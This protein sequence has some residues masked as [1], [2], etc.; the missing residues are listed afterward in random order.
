M[1]LRQRAGSMLRA[2]AGLA[3]ILRNIPT[4]DLWY[5][6]RVTTAMRGGHP[7]HCPICGF[8][9][10]FRAFGSPPRYDAECPKCR[11]LER[12]R[13]LFLAMETTYPIQPGSA[14]LHFAPEPAVQAFVRSRVSKYVTTDIIGS[15]VD[16]NLN[17]EKIALPDASYDVIVCS[18]VLEHV[19]D[20]FALAEMYRVLRP[21]GSLYVMA[22]VIEGWERTYENDAID[23]PHLREIYFGQIDHVR[24]Y[25]S[26]IRKRIADAGFEFSE[27]TAEGAIVV[28]H[29]LWRGEKIFVCLKPSHVE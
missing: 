27:F 2:S 22:P 12:H 23:T 16:L 8:R 29:G 24:F 4:L 25:G 13:L 28:D 7:R 9:G 21:G 26:D 6:A 18:H 15:H 10:Y 1:T 20:Y 17:I 11:S 5:L 19:D 14:L 3:I